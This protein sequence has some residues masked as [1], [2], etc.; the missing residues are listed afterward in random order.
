MTQTL[1][2]RMNI[3][4][5]VEK[6]WM[7]KMSKTFLGCA[8]HRAIKCFLNVKQHKNTHTHTHT[9]HG[10]RTIINFFYYLR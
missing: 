10:E 8:K 7:L 6:K 9:K 4:K 2:A 5:K 1:Y 3:I